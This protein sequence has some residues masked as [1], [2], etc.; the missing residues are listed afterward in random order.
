MGDQRI[1]NKEVLHF[2]NS[3]IIP[4]T[5]DNVFEYA[6][7]HANFSSHMSK[8]S[9]M[10]G[11]GSMNS[12]T[13]EKKFQAVGSHLQMK[14]TVFGV[15]LFLDE[16]ITKHDPPYRKEWQTVGDINLVV[17]GHYSLG[18]EIKPEENRFKVYIDYELPKSLKT[19]W[20]GKL[21]G[22]FYARWCV[23]QMISGVKEHFK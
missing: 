6:D 9:W 11:G 23:E 7:N 21:F 22:E 13:D 19:L 2:E 5:S 12:H 15:K 1:M 17:I 8:S 18:F 14:G 10:M 3:V 20:L 4:A 16:V